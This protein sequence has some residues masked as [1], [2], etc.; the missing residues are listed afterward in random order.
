MS[1]HT[2]ADLD[3]VYVKILPFLS[4]E[5]MS[6]FLAGSKSTVSS[7]GIVFFCSGFQQFRDKVQ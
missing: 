4:S 7:C 1:T 6:T 5:T 2:N 3:W